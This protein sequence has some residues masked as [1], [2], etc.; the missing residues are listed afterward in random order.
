MIEAPV[1]AVKPMAVHDGPGI[2]STLFLKGCPL[3]CCWCHNPETIAPEPQ[4]LFRDIRCVDCGRCAPSCPNQAHGLD[5][6]GKHVF[7]RARC[8]A[9]GACEEAC[10]HDA[11]QF[12]GRPMTPSQAAEQLLEDVDFFRVSGGGVTISGGEP[13][14]YPDFCAELLEIVGRERVHRA[15]DTSGFADWAAFS[16]VL[17]ETDLVLFDVKHID[18]EAHRRYTGGSNKPILDNLE[19]LAD[20]GVPIEIRMPVIPGINTSDDVIQ[21]TGLFLSRL[22]NVTGV[23]LLPFHPYGTDKYRFLG[24]APALPEARSPSSGE[25]DAIVKSLEGHGL[26]VFDADVEMAQEHSRPAH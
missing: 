1:A 16:R 22:P 15:L 24:Q 4:L 18:D 19:R 6:S 26:N 13:L 2:R 9:C 11:L 12:C 25:L 10:L 3:S 17:S 20:T 14:L 7:D 21:R 23:R 8:V 5:E